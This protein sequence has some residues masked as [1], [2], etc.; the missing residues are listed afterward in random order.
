MSV[1]GLSK[2]LALSTAPLEPLAAACFF[3]GIFK[4]QR[5]KG[6][7]I[8]VEVRVEVRVG[9]EQAGQACEDTDCADV[10]EFSHLE[11]SHHVDT[12]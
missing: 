7:G 8:R 2:L 4:I 3:G 11:N 10:S 6:K 12:Y 1:L 9:F 5:Y